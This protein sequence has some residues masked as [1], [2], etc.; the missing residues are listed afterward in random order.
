MNEKWIF[1]QEEGLK[2]FLDAGIDEKG[3]FYPDPISSKSF[4]S[5]QGVVV[6]K[7]ILPK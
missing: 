4:N 1:L 5:L 2:Y 6:K 7:T 3:V